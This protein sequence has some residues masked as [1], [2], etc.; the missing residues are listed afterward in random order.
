MNTAI[1]NARTE[2]ARVNETQIDNLGIP[3]LA[4]V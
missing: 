2:H 1:R 4:G 3:P